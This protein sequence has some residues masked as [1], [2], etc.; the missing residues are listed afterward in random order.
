VIVP[1]VNIPGSGEIDVDEIGFEPVQESWNEYRLADGATLRLRLVLAAVY[2]VPGARD[3]DGNPI[4]AARSTNVMS[5][6]TPDDL[7]EES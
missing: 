5:V 6:E 3:A 2:R 7:R 1:R 4:Y